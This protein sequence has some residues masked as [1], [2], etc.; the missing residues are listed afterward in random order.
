MAEFRIEGRS[1]AGEPVVGYLD[2]A[3]FKQ[4]K[5]KARLIAEQRRFILDAVRPRQTFVFCVQRKD[6]KPITGTQTA[7][8]K[9]QVCDALRRLGFKVLRVNRK[10]LEL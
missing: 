8:S 1:R 9:E 10:L 3:D 2:A 4:A 6:E 7:F 5:E